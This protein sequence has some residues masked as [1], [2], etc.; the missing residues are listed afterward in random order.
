MGWA[1]YGHD[2]EDG[3]PRDIVTHTP[4]AMFLRERAHANSL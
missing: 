4:G 3:L 1:E 2:C